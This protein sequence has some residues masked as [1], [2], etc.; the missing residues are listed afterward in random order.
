M[1]TRVNLKG[2]QAQAL[3]LKTR[4]FRLGLA[5]HFKSLTA[6]TETLKHQIN[7]QLIN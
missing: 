6:F 2:L 1:Q 7:G 3:R 4:R 5:P